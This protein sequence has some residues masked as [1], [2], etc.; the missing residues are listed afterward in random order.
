MDEPQVKDILGSEEIPP[1]EDNARKQA[2]NLALVAF[3]DVQRDK[4]KKT[5]RIS[6]SGSSN[7]S[8]Q[9]TNRETTHGKTICIR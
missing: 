4:Q 8:F 6:A 7:R 3:D 2:I 9:L 1:A 5:P